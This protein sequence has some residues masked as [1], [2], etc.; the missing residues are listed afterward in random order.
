MPALSE[1]IQPGFKT[2]LVATPPWSLPNGNATPAPAASEKWP[3]RRSVAFGMSGAS[4]SRS[5][6]TTNLFTPSPGA[7][8]SV[9]GV[10]AGAGL[11]G[12]AGSRVSEGA[13]SAGAGSLGTVGGG[14]A[15]VVAG[16]GPGAGGAADGA[17]GF[18]GSV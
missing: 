10:A 17:G 9:D 11:A 1:N 15:G 16:G 5:S 8:P 14:E 12:S 6:T 4:G 3:A 18:A 2:S 7:A 13:G